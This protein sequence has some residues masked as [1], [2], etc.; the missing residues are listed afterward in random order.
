M[1]FMSGKNR[2]RGRCASN[3]IEPNLQTLTFGREAVENRANEDGR[4]K[5]E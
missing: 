5:D 3:P 4:S 1:A 2:M